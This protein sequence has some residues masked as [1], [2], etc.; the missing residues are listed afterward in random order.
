MTQAANPAPQF[1]V[2]YFDARLSKKGR[3]VQVATFT[4]RA[5]AEAF[6]AKNRIYAAPCKV[7]VAS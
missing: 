3:G 2:K 6:A 1:R 4:D 5:E 7:E